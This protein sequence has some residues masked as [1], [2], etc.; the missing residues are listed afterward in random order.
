MFGE[1]FEVDGVGVP[2]GLVGFRSNGFEDFQSCMIVVDRHEVYGVGE[3]CC[4]SLGVDQGGDGEDG[5]EVVKAALVDGGQSS[6]VG[7]V[8]IGGDLVGGWD[9]EVVGQFEDGGV[10]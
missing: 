2:G 3:C 6:F 7:V 9:A 5:R 8:E 1:A 4:C 10:S